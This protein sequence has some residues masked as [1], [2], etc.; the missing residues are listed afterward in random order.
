MVSPEER[1]NES[2]KFL[3]IDNI[4]DSRSR[5]NRVASRF[6]RHTKTVKEPRAQPWQFLI[7]LF[8]S[9]RHSPTSE[10]Y[11]KTYISLI[12]PDPAKSRMLALSPARDLFTWSSTSTTNT[13]RHSSD[14]PNLSNLSN[15]LSLNQFTFTNTYRQQPFVETPAQRRARFA[16]VQK[17]SREGE[18]REDR[19]QSWVQDQVQQSAFMVNAAKLSSSSEN[20]KSRR[21]KNAT[22]SHRRQASFVP[23]LST[24]WVPDEIMLSRML[25]DSSNMSLSSITEEEEEQEPYVLYST[26]ISS[27]PFPSPAPYYHSA[28]LSPPSSPPRPSHQRRLSDLE[29]IPEE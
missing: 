10:V 7:N 16:F 11:I 5:Q 1:Q 17:D 27:Y 14:L 18:K 25:K 9:R 2:S 19:V 4:A 23:S 20:D 24:K 15:P 3:G 6:R 13:P 12:V 26:P 21:R 22:S 29:V 8:V 28:P